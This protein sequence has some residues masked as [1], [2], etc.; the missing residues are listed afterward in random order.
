MTPLPPRPTWT[1]DGKG[2]PCTY[3]AALLDPDVA[4]GSALDLAAGFDRLD[5]VTGLKSAAIS[6][7][8]ECMSDALAEIALR[9]QG[10]IP[11]G[12]SE[13]P[14][15]W[16]VG[17]AAENG[18]SSIGLMLVHAE[19]RGA[20]HIR[21]A[22][23]PEMTPEA[24]AIKAEVEARMV[25]A[26]VTPVDLVL[27]E[28]AGKKVPHHDELRAIMAEPSSWTRPS[29]GA[30][31]QGL[32]A[33]AINLGPQGGRP[34]GVEE[35]ISLTDFTKLVPGAKW[36]PGQHLEAGPA[37][38]Y[39]GQSETLTPNVSSIGACPHLPMM[40]LSDLIRANGLM[41]LVAPRAEIAG[42]RP[43]IQYGNERDVPV[44]DA[45]HAIIHASGGLY[46]ASVQDRVARFSAG[47]AAHDVGR[48]LEDW[49][50]TAIE[51]ISEGVTSAERSFDCNDMRDICHAG[52]EGSR[53][54]LRLET[55]HGSFR[56]DMMLAK[57]GAVAEVLAS[58]IR[59]GRDIPVGRFRM[60]GR[61]LC[62]EYGTDIP[63]DIRS[64]RDMNGIIGSLASVACVW[65]DERP[66]NS[67][68]P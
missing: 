5:E 47:I 41:P 50:R 43:W 12:L 22:F 52:R 57:G 45:G 62:A 25:A 42:S 13:T 68:S 55:Q 3:P 31:F 53:L 49:T 28:V 27:A 16:R 17:S 36:W 67:P 32:I 26:G 24:K 39:P 7:A 66:G 21:V 44:R 33:T 23:V 51:M 37:R 54:W 1:L 60:T 15:G 11:G 64:I 2:I 35:V 19:G 30:R 20:W 61:G 56:L 34:E 9:A 46:D 4:I 59:G 10:A 48:H 29:R 63:Y 40:I 18:P 8:T 58:R 6:H 65:Q 14:D 38:R